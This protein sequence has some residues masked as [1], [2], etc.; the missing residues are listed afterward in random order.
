MSNRHV[1]IFSSAGPREI[2]QLLRHL[3]DAFPHL[4]VS[5]LYERSRSPLAVAPRTSQGLS[6]S[7]ILVLLRSAFYGSAARIRTAT[8]WLLDLLLRLLHAAPKYPNAKSLSLDELRGYA[9]S[10]RVE[11]VLAEDCCS[12][13]S[14]KLV[15]RLQPDLGV[16]YGA[17]VRDVNLLAMPTKGSIALDVHEHGNCRGTGSRRPSEAREAWVERTISAH[18]VSDDVDDTAAIAERTVPIQ[19]YDTPESIA[20]KSRLLGVE[21]LVDAIRLAIDP[22][23]INLEL[24]GSSVAARAEGWAQRL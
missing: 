19:E 10:K 8:I 14:K 4:R 22:S 21:C 6:F 5:V 2:K 3:T 20:V 16:V 12:Q 18:Y 15:R 13:I 11:F 24:G 7:S 9:E 1:I 23:G 17:P